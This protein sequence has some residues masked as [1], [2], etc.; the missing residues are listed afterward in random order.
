MPQTQED[1]VL[2]S[3][4]REALIVF[5][6]W[7]A[8]MTWSV[9]YCYLNGYITDAARISDKQFVEVRPPAVSG[10]IPELWVDRGQGS[11][12]VQFV[13]GFPAWIFWGVA[14]PWWICTAFSIFFG[15][16]LVRDEDL[17][18]DPEAAAEAAGQEVLHA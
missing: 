5:A 18:L 13:L 8:A 7:L 1:P 2:I 10:G 16:F 6:C 15:A 4:R 3:A 11:Q 17:G 9:G 14:L 12:R